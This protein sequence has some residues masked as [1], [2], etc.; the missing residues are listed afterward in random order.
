MGFL[1]RTS[2]AQ[3]ISLALA[4]IRHRP[5]RLIRPF[6][7]ANKKKPFSYTKT[8]KVLSDDLLEI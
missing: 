7:T 6:T 1:R 4:Q 2:P 3:R 8:K 5:E